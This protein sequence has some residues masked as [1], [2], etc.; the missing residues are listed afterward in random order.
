MKIPKIAHNTLVILGSLRKQPRKRPRKQQSPNYLL[1]LPVELILCI[2][3]F[4]NPPDLILFSQTCYSLRA[5]LQKH[6]I[7][8]KLSRA[9]YLLYLT[10]CAREQPNKWVCKKCAT[11]H[12]IR[13]LD[14]PAVGFLRSSCPRRSYEGFRLGTP[15]WYGQMRVQLE[16]RHI[17]LAFKY[18][19]L[20]QDKYKSY[21]KALLAPHHDMG[22]SPTDHQLKIYYSTYPK[23]ATAHNGNLTFLL[24]SSW[25]Y[26]KDK[27][28]G[29][30]LFDKIGYLP[31]SPH[32]IIAPFWTWRP[33]D[34]SYRLQ[35]AIKSALEA[36][37]DSQEHKGAC[38]R[39]ATDFSVQSDSQFLD[40]HVWQDF[41]PEGSPG[42]LAWEIH[43]TGTT[44]DGVPNGWGRGRGPTLYHEPG[45]IRKLYGKCENVKIRATRAS[46]ANKAVGI[47]HRI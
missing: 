12:P 33:Q 17:Q 4:L 21:L 22:F 32:V 47:F 41:G 14:T 26:Y 30:I 38:P 11:L 3:D 19:R 27:L 7:T 45:T 18:T 20:Q 34:S 44:I 36:E 13:K 39:C 15:L 2:A 46:L 29:K 9:E 1:Q 31:I 43:H 23:I 16:H 37:G 5:I 35:E 40:L 8:T 42:D 10:A 6:T 25:R 28:C 24:L